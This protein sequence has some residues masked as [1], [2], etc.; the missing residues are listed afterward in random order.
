MGGFTV[1]LPTFQQWFSIRE[2]VEIYAL[3][4]HLVESWCPHCGAGI[5]DSCIC[6]CR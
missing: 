1:Y 2:G 3:C 6:W 5:C 4:G